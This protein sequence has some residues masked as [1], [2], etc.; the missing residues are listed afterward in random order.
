MK[1][2]KHL[3]AVWKVRIILFVADQ[4]DITIDIGLYP[5]NRRNKF[6]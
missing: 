4:L 2:L 1:I 3:N 5:N 6:F